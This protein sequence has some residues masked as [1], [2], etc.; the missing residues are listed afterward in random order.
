MRIKSYVFLL[1]IGLL[2][3]STNAQVNR[4][5][6]TTRI[7]FIFDESNS[8]NGMWDNEKKIEVSKRLMLELLDS[9]RTINNLQLA[10]RMYG[11]QYPVPPQVC[12]DSKLEVPFADD[13]IDQ[14]EEKI[15]STEPKGTTPIAFSLERCARDFPPCNNCRNVVVLITDGIEEC[16]GDPCAIALALQSKKIIVKPYVIGIGLDVTL[17]DAFSCMGKFYNA[18]NEYEFREILKTVVDEAINPTSCQIYLNDIHGN[19]TETDVNMTLYDAKTGELKENL[20]HTMNYANEPDTLYLDAETTYKIDVHTIPKVVIENAK[21]FPGKH[22]II[23]TDAPQGTLVVNEKVSNRLKGTKFI[24][25]QYKKCN[26]LNIQ[27]IEKPEKYIVGRYDL[28]IL[29]LPRL[30]YRGVEIRQSETTT[31]RIPQPGVATISCPTDGYA[32]L[33]VK[34]KGKLKWVINLNH[35]KSESLNLMPGNYVVVYRS[36]S[37]RSSYATIVKEFKIKSG[38]SIYVKTERF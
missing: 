11:H 23:S 7:L 27:E 9:L 26:T 19:P 17:I 35:I 28:E 4:G 13:N 15:L 32:S 8:M 3:F 10:L 12:S 14:I 31:I 37:M 38:H 5:N 21:I 2:S 24:V 22:T 25:R 18:N 33:Y 20:M 16:D 29:T 1:I 34:E 36:G 6:I 30:Y